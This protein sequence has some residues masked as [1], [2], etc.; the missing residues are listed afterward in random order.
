MAAEDLGP[1]LHDGVVREASLTQ[2]ERDVL[3]A[4]SAGADEAGPTR[5]REA[6]VPAAL[7]AISRPGPSLADRRA[8]AV[9]KRHLAEFGRLVDFRIFGSRTRG[10]ATWD[11]DLDIFIELENA[12]AATR[13]RIN[14][15]A[16][17]V[18][19][20]AGLVIAP[21]VVTREDIETGPVG[22]SPIIQHILAEGV[23]V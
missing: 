13:Q 18:G 7:Y 20:A 15:L 6:G 22:A 1:G 19:F 14:E 9:L 10:S 12:T 17:E 3:A 8:A 16:W 11:S 4:G 23:P 5:L 2:E 21:F